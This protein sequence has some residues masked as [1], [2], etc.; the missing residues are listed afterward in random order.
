M[1]NKKFDNIIL[2]VLLGAALIIIAVCIIITAIPRPKNSK[3]EKVDL[4][5]ITE[6]VKN[7]LKECK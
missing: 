3:A 6:P 4:E 1:K 7:P 2:G 5:C